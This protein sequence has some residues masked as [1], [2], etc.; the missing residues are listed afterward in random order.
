MHFLRLVFALSSASIAAAWTT[1]IVPHSGGNDDTL[2]LAA[3]LSANKALATNATILFQTGITYNILT[4]IAFPKFQNVIVSIQGNITYAADVKKTQAI[5]ASS[6]F[7][8]HWFTFSGTNVTLTGSQDPNWGWVNANGQ[9]W[10]DAMQKVSSRVNRPHGW[11]F[12][13]VQT[14]EIVNMKLWQPVAWSFSVTGSNNV[15]IHNNTIIAVSYSSSF[16]S[17]TDGFDAEGTNLVFENNIVYNGDDCLAVGSPASNIVFR[18]SYCNGGHGLSIGSLGKGGSV[19]NVQDILIENVVMENSVYGARFKS[20]TGGKGTAKNVTWRDITLINVQLPIYITQHY[21][22][23]DVSQGSTNSS[24]Q[25]STYLDTFTFQN[26]QG[27]IDDSKGNG[28]T[29]STGK[30]VVIFDLFQGTSKSLIA[31]DI[32]T[33]TVSGSNVMVMC[34]SS[35]VSNDVGF[36]CWDG[37]YEPTIAGA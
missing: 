28:V 13:G 19:A 2:A 22:D 3:A 34:D 32:S 21:W 4:P 17:N 24:Y 7:P 9:K 23:Q 33:T 20:W 11:S 25:T 6:S 27:T 12:K 5:V 10:W 16:P 29:G 1:Y 35:T 15:H 8:G 31:K 14:G 26:F 18:N 36:K 37:Q 30:E